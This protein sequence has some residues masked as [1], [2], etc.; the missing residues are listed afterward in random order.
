VVAALIAAAT[1]LFAVRGPAAVSLRD[2][3]REANVNLGLIHRY[4]GGKQDLL[5]AVLSRRPGMPPLDDLTRRSPE[6]II[7]LLLTLLA[8]DTTYIKVVL[9]A[10]LDGFDVPRLQDAFPVIRLAAASVR[11]ELPRRDADV[12]VA[13]LAAAAMG[14]QAAGP[15]MLEVLEQGG[16]TQSDLTEVL[17][18]PLLAFLTEEPAT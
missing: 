10:T 2:V 1:G 18:P 13:L 4:I 3:A 9:R 12:R 17:R 11:H 15:A 8:A 16:L 14:W 5:A 7:D 6:E